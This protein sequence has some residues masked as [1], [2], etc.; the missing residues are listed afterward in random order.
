MKA[1]NELDQLLEL[2][3]VKEILI[4]GG[5][6][7]TS[8]IYGPVCGSIRYLESKFSSNE[9]NMLNE[10]IRFEMEIRRRRFQKIDRKL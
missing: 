5:P 6:T 2:K 10:K 9:I 8:N 1:H 7:W 4:S 3:R